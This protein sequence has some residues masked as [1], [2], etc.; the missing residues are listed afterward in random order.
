MRWRAWESG[1]LP[2]SD[3][4]Q[5]RYGPV[6]A[7]IIFA[8]QVYPMLELAIGLLIVALIAGALGFTGVAKGAASIAKII[9]VAF[10]VIAGLIF[11]LGLLGV[12][13]IF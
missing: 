11:L 7:T 3:T 8:Q 5:P 9:F 2:C 1:I 12:I 13:A 10:L 4:E 6:V